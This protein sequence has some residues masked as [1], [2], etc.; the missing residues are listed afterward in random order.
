NILLMSLSATC[1]S[2]APNSRV[3]ETFPPSPT[4]T[5]RTQPKMTLRICSSRQIISP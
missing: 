5:D 4:A 3:F 2:F 1:E